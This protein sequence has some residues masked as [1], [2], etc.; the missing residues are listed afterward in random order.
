MAN[1]GDRALNQ[2]AKSSSDVNQPMIVAICYLAGW[3]TGGVSGIVAVVL[4][5][6]WQGENKEEWAR[7]HYTYLVRTF[8]ISLIAGVIGAVL[9]LVLI[10]FLILMIVPVW[11]TVRAVVSLLK[12]QKQEPMPDPNTLLF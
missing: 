7:S 10:G 12:A 11:V 1:E 3:M 6:I 9:T 2:P 8:W 5:Y 4:A